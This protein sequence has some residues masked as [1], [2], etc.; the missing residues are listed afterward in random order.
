MN[1]ALT[2]LAGKLDWFGL[3]TGIN[4]F[5]LNSKRLRSKLL[6]KD[7]RFTK[8]R[9]DLSARRNKVTLLERSLAI[10]L[11]ALCMMNGHDVFN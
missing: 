1:A 9:M 6:A 8:N 2:P 7:R 11:D 10:S 3:L 5:N 4:G